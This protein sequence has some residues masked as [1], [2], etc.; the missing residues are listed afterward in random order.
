MLQSRR[1]K[2]VFFL[3]SSAGGVY[4]GSPDRP[5]FDENSAV[6]AISPYG[7]QKLAQEAAAR[8][9][10][11]RSQTP[12]LIG[13]IS[14]LYG[15]GQNLSKPQG[16]ITHIGRSALRREP[17]TIFVSLDTIR[18]Y[19]LASDAGELILRAVRQL[20]SETAGESA[21]LF[22]K[23][24]AAQRESSIATVLAIWRAIL[25]RN[26]RYVQRST[27]ASALQPPQLVFRS[28]RWSHLDDQPT[29]LSIGIHSVFRDLM[30]RYADGHM[31][32]GAPRQ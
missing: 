14:N 26:P 6:G 27:P 30:A 10:A 17:I 5:P 16:L 19:L 18:D 22:L 32:R 20:E 8:A 7:L 28:T 29:P 13:R 23:I 1:P 31:S 4:G 12:L 24:I 21:P 2:G 9:F 15:P 25:K 11:V 3:A